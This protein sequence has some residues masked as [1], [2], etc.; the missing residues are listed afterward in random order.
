MTVARA[1]LILF[2]MVVVGVVMVGVRSESAKAANR[3]QKLHE[4]KVVLKQKLWS[5]ELE[6]AQLRG[7]E[8]IR[9]RAVEMQL[10]VVP[11]AATDQD[12][13]KKKNVP[14]NTGPLND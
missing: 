8:A 4:R 3:I 5:K 12:K 2:L 6:L 7:P 10:D 14:P 9:R 1:L 11:P 13:A